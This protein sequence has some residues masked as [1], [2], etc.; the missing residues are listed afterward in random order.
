[1]RDGVN[2]EDVDPSNACQSSSPQQPCMHSVHFD[3]V[4]KAPL[5]RRGKAYD[6]SYAQPANQ[7]YFADNKEVSDAVNDASA[8]QKIGGSSCSNFQADQ[9][10]VYLLVKGSNSV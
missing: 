2:A 5:L 6:L 3:V 7:Q 1:M 9:V 8:C 4:Y 10:S